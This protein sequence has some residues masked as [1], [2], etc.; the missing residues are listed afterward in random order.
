MSNLKAKRK[1]ATEAELDKILGPK[2]V[3]AKKDEPIK[4]TGL[5]DS[6]AG[7]SPGMLKLLRLLKEAK[8]K[9]TTSPPPRNPVD[10]GGL[11]R[12]AR[13]GR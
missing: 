1:K 9:R 4:P 5:A 8:K 13:S 6:V 2:E 12:F 10:T 11:G 3:S 7:Y